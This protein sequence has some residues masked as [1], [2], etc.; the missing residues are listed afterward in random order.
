[1]LMRPTYNYYMEGVNNNDH[2]ALMIWSY[3]IKLKIKLNPNK[4]GRKPIFVG[5]FSND[6]L[7]PMLSVMPTWV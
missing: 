6:I 1:M 5:S 4:I 7:L 3:K 2:K